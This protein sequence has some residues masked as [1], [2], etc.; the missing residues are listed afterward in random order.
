MISEGLC[1]LILCAK[2]I[3]QRKSLS[4]VT[5]VS[6]DQGLLQTAIVNDT[7]YKEIFYAKYYF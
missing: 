1:S 7:L 3:Q 4:V 2:G 6:R 5:D